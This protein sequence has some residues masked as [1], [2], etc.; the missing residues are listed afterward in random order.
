MPPPEPRSRT[1]SPSCRSATASGLPHPRL[2]RTASS[3]SPSVSPSP[4]SGPPKQS[5]VSSAAEAVP[6]QESAAELPQRARAEGRPGAG[7]SRT[8]RAASAYR[9]LTC[10]AQVCAGLIRH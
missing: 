8:A 10:F 5:A 6:Q 4:Y 9:A 2:A 1:R 7:R 3:G